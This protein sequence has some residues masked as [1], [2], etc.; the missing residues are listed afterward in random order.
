MIILY[1]DETGIYQSLYKYLWDFRMRGMWISPQIIFLICCYIYQKGAMIQNPHN[2]QLNINSNE[3]QHNS[4]EP[5][6]RAPA[7]KDY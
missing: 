3:V 6:V 7:F 5:S 1:L 2:T 4:G